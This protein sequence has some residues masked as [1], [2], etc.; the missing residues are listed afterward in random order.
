MNNGNYYYNYL[1]NSDCYKRLSNAIS[2]LEL[3]IN[4]VKALNK[5]FDDASGNN[6]TAI[7]NDLSGIENDLNNYANSLKNIKTKLE[8]NGNSFD[9]TLTTWRKRVGKN[10][11]KPVKD[12]LVSTGI[13][14]NVYLSSSEIIVNAFANSDTGH[15]IVRTREKVSHTTHDL[16]TDTKKTNVITNELHDY[17]EDF[18][19][20]DR[21]GWW[22]D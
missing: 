1:I 21:S 6:I 20:E 10:Y 8:S 19:A 4:N 12:Q 7:K 2:D 15:V 17:E 13:N 3:Q 16:A 5:A 14:S 11:M 22:N 18:G 9:K